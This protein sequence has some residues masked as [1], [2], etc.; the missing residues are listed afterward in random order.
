M[1]GWYIPGLSE[2]PLRNRLFS[3]LGEPF[4][5]VFVFLISLGTFGYSFLFS[6]FRFVLV[7]V[8]GALHRGRARRRR[9]YQRVLA[10][11]GG[12]ARSAVAVLVARRCVCV[13]TQGK[14][15]WALSGL[16]LRFLIDYV[17]VFKGRSGLQDRIQ[18]VLI[19]RTG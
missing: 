19:L 10:G 12:V 11:R 13:E 4:L 17:R 15:E 18:A 7:R 1:L 9:R 16:H 5:R 3:L 6:Y 8:L 2:L 14:H